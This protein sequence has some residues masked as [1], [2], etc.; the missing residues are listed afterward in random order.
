M[1]TVSISVDDATK[2]WLDG[3]S[4]ELGMSRSATVQHIIANHFNLQKQ[5]TAFDFLKDERE[6]I[7]SGKSV[8]NKFD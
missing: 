1:K 7:Y 5:K 4:K 2:E 8:L 3:L 6:D